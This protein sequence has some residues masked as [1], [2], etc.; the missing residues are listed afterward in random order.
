MRSWVLLPTLDAA[1]NA[2]SAIF[3]LLGYRFIRRKN[4]VAHKRCM[5]TAFALSIAFLCVYLLHHAQVGSVPYRGSGAMRTLYFVLLVPHV[6]LAAAVPPLAIVTIRRA[7]AGR[8][9][10][11]RSLARKTL[12]IWLYV[13]VTGVIVYWMLYR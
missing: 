1:L 6:M 4:V 11:H 10:E 2:A 12:P 8:F 13:S 3:L 9:V 7:L 5:L